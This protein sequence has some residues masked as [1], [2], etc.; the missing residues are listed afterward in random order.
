MRSEPV[1]MHVCHLQGRGGR[2]ERGKDER[3]SG[4]DRNNPQVLGKEGYY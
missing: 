4:N 1:D 2:R 3:V